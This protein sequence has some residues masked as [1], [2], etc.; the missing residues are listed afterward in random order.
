MIKKY[1]FILNPNARNSGSLKE[2]ETI[3]TILEEKGVDYQLLTTERPAHATELARGVLQEDPE[4]TIIAVG[5]DGTLHEVVNGIIGFPRATLGFIGAGSGNDYCRGAR[6]PMNSVE[7]INNILSSAPE[8]HQLDCGTFETTRQGFFAGSMGLGIDADV[9]EEVND[10]T[11]KMKFNKMRLGK[12][13]YLYTFFKSLWTFKHPNVEVTI[14]GVSETYKKV[15][16][17]N[18]ANSP[19]FGGGILISPDAKMNDGLFHIFI[20]HSYS[21]L[22]IMFMFFSIIWGGQTK[23][24]NTVYKTGK[25]ISLKPDINSVIHADGEIV[26]YG[27]LQVDI[28]SQS[29]N[30]TCQYSDQV[31][32][33]NG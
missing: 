27:E 32:T 23:L 14:D 13:A 9:T 17:V 21:R 4:A 7:A 12:L 18:I 1:F 3:R 16:M 6:I 10:S 5:G 2:W 31:S 29:L 20:V 25:K 15:W 28:L 30:V 22:K 33:E 11:L 19:Y 26:G 24:R 8:I